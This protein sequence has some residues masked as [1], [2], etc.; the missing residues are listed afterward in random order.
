MNSKWIQVRFQNESNRR[1][2]ILNFL[3]NFN[4]NSIYH[5]WKLSDHVEDSLK[6]DGG[7]IIISLPQ[8]IATQKE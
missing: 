6:I 7:A 5:Y 8:A 1:I 3:F 4:E 2:T